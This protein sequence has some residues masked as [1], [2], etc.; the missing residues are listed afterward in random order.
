[1][2]SIV[3]NQIQL[4]GMGAVVIWLMGTV[5]QWVLGAFFAGGVARLLLAGARRAEP[6]FGAIFEGGPWFGKML[7]V[8]VLLGILG[9]A[10]ACISLA[11]AGVMFVRDVGLD[12]D[13]SIDP[14]ALLRRASHVS[15]D[16]WIALL[17]GGLLLTVLIAFVTLRLMFA[18]YYVVD[19]GH[20][21][22][23]ALGASWQATRGQVLELLGFSVL[24][25][26]LA[27]G[28]VMACCLPVFLVVAVARVAEAMIYLCIAG[29]ASPS[30]S[31]PA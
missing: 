6:S 12:K 10:L 4:D 18:Q 11:P 13:P 27:A 21:V 1:V 29:R 14:E 9:A 16:F 22:I 19:L 17:A 25:L 8:N 30:P 28:G 31:V 7:G 3:L 20:G 26:L 23:D 15:A 5:T 2:P 24:V